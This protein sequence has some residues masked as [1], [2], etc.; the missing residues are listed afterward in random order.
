MLKA[1]P[2]PAYGCQGNEH[3][4]ILSKQTSWQKIFETTKGIS[5]PPP[6]SLFVEEFPGA[7][8][9]ELIKIVNLLTD[10]HNA[11]TL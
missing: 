9:G 7:T 11:N 6:A 4:T 1:Q 5:Q 10:N 8:S 2:F 3:L